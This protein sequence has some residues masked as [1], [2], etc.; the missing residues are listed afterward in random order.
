MIV[1]ATA[2]ITGIASR[3]RNDQAAHAG[4]Q[5]Q[6]CALRMKGNFLS[7]PQVY[8]EAHVDKCTPIA[9]AG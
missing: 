3:I 5:L 8:G 6:L 2:V 4:A 1:C 9:L 7:L